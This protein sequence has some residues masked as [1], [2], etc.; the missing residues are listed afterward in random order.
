VT[1][2]DGAKTLVRIPS[3]FANIYFVRRGSFILCTGF[4]KPKT[5][6]LASSSVSGRRTLEGDADDF[7]VR[8]SREGKALLILKREHHQRPTLVVVYPFYAQ[9]LRRRRA[10]SPAN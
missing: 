8:R 10:K 4:A 7:D 6:L 9:E 1:K 5:T 2:P 3:R